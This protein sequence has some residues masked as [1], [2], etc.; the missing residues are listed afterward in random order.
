[1]LGGFSQDNY[2]RDD[3][4]DVIRTSG[5]LQQPCVRGSTALD[6]VGISSLAPL[7]K[8]ATAKRP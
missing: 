3:S 4:F 1:M 8:L 6:D 7:K 2:L 5:S